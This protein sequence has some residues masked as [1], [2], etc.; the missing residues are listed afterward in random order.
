MPNPSLACPARHRRL[1]RSRVP[2]RSA[3]N[4]P[5]SSGYS[6]RPT[7]S[8]VFEGIG[9]TWLMSVEITPPATCS[10]GALEGKA[11]PFAVPLEH[12]H[13]EWGQTRYHGGNFRGSRREQRALPSNDAPAAGRN[14]WLTPRTK[15]PPRCPWGGGGTVQFPTCLIGTGRGREVGGLE[16]PSFEHVGQAEVPTRLSI[17][18]RRGKK[19]ANIQFL[20]KKAT[21]APESPSRRSQILGPNSAPGYP[22][23]SV[24]NG[25]IE[26]PGFILGCGP[27]GRSAMTR[28]RAV[29]HTRFSGIG[30]DDRTLRSDCRCAGISVRVRLARWDEGTG[31]PQGRI[32]RLIFKA[33]GRASRTSGS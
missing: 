12:G 13:H 4:S 29:E 31:S 20:T 33:C 27:R 15:A 16:H 23:L 8:A 17:P 30:D 2:S 18:C 3:V 25:G 26:L 19:D 5:D 28:T 22:V 32:C 10:G 21:L 9:C 11:R 7:R 1:P 14:R 24:T 6:A